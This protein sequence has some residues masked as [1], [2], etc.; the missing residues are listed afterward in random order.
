MNYEL[1]NPFIDSAETEREGFL[2]YVFEAAFFHHQHELFR[3]REVHHR[4]RKI[5]ISL[6]VARDFL[7]DERKYIKEIEFIQGE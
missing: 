1:T 5:G 6:V 4:I 2:F 3:F 7:S